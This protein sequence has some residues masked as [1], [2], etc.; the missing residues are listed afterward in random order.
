M[1]WLNKIENRAIK[2]V[3]I[4]VAGRKPISD[5]KKRHEMHVRRDKAFDQLVTAVEG[6]D[7]AC[8]IAEARMAAYYKRRN[9][10]VLGLKTK[11]RR[12]L[13]KANAT[14]M[15]EAVSDARAAAK[16]NSHV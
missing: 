14:R 8:V 7:R 2:L 9:A 16:E 12:S 5:R 15:R 10:A 11:K 13:E 6:Y 3:R 4:H 1:D